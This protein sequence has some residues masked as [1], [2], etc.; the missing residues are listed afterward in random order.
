[1]QVDD[2]VTI[3]QLTKRAAVDGAEEM[4]L[5]LDK[6]TGGDSATEDLT[7]KLSRVVQLTGFSGENKHTEN[8]DHPLTYDQIPFTQKHMSKSSSLISF[9]MS[10]WLIRQRRHCRTSPLNSQLW[11]ISKW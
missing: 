2:V 7:S 10:S 9:W 4:G 1:V 5:D 6:A 8:L 3:R 11:E